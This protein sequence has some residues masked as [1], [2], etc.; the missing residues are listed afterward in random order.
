MIKKYL[1]Y[2]AL[3]VL[4]IITVW[5]A[6]MFRYCYKEDTAET[7]FFAMDTY[8]S[9]KATGR[10]PEAAVEA[11]RS[12]I[13]A[14][15]AKLSVTNSESVVADLNK[16]CTCIADED[17]IYLLQRVLR[18]KNCLRVPSTCAYTLS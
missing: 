15:D 14:L 17:L 3:F 4:F 10:N 5:A 7:S 12:A 9:V 1:K 11:V 2:I 18:P 13:E 16:T 8:M 6:L